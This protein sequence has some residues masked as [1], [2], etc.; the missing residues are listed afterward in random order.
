MDELL[1]QA[2]QLARGMWLYRRLG[3]LAAWGV[4][5]IAALVIFLIPDKYEA[6]AR[7][8]VDT[9]SVLRPLMVGLAVQSNAEQQIAMLS[10]T[11]ISRPNM[12]RLVRMAD[13]DLKID[14]KGEREALIEHLTKTLSIRSA[15]RDN[16]YTLSY[17]DPDPAKATK[18][19]QSLTTI[20]VESSLGDKQKDGDSARKFIDEQIKIY[21][22]KLA[23]AEAR[24]KEFKLRNMDMQFDMGDGAGRFNE[25]TTQLSQAR[26]QLREAENGR[27]AIKRQILGS[28]AAASG[29][30]L[31]VPELD[32]RID[33]LKRNLDKLLQTYT[34]QHP[35]VVG[36]RRMIKELEEQRRVEVAERR[37]VGASNPTALLGSDN[38]SLAMRT[39][40]SGA[41]AQVASLRARVSEYEARLARAKEGMRL[42]PEIE[43]EYAQLNRDYAINK[44]NY[45][46]LVER[47][48]SAVMSSDMDSLGGIASFRLIDPPR[49]SSSP[50]APNRMLLLPL[51]LLGSLIAGAMVCLL[52]SKIRPTFSDARTLREFAGLPL[53][54]TVSLIVSDEMRAKHRK[55]LVKLG[56]AT[57]ALAAVYGIEMLVLLLIGA[58]A[59]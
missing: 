41:E 28:D 9:D 33:A 48:E 36:A 38:V 52:A 10:R 4:G 3:V 55:S 29:G 2:R 22:K 6:S 16:L 25:L 32:A 11:L 7:I 12:E 43:A 31:A 50:V 18:V 26:L 39:Q 35:D 46:N 15:G 59:A 14:S 56:A 13:L 24:L 54:G 45:E 23:D 5:L 51:A 27:D 40:L 53:L 21:E 57:S 34:E 30:D 42:M 17:R 1:R 19:V 20:F 8:F 37:K 58:K 47:R 44:K 49:A